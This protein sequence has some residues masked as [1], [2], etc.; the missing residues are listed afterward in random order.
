MPDPL[1]PTDANAR[2]A[3][4]TA[5][6]TQRGLEERR[7]FAKVWLAAEEQRI[8]HRHQHG[9]GGLEIVRARAAAF[10]TVLGAF[11]GNALASQDRKLPAMALVAIGNYGRA[12]L[13][14][15][16]SLR[17][18]VLLAV[19]RETQSAVQQAAIQEFIDTLGGLGVKTSHL[20]G[21]IAECLALATADSHLKTSFID[22]RLIGGD[23]E[24]FHRFDKKFSRECLT[25]G[26]AEL[27]EFLRQAG[28]LH[29]LDRSLVIQ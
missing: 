22:A 7:V 28:H 26:Q 9:G 8:E 25:K 11:F 19:A 4:N 5:L 21:S 27:C 15:R 10:D 3:F 14:P 12:A 24:L 29:A 17:C 18:M 2:H 13:S 16:S 1:Q 6:Q 20:C 23:A